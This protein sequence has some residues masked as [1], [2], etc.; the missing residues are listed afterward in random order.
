M[1]N[2]TSVLLPGITGFTLKIILEPA[3]MP[4]AD[5]AIGVVYPKFE[6]V[7]KVK[8]AEVGPPQV[9]VAGAGLSKSKPGAAF[10]MVKLLLE[11]SK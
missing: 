6:M 1:V 4:E 11:M 7:P 3:G 2:V 5:N 8:E 10:V 9:I